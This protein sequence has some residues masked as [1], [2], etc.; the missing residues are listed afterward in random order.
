MLR[1]STLSL[2][3]LVVASLI[4]PSVSAQAA[5][6]PSAHPHVAEA[7]AVA[8]VVLLVREIRHARAALQTAA[9]LRERP[10]TADAPIE[11]VLCGGGSRSLLADAP[12]AA[13]L[14]DAAAAA[15]VQLL[16][17]GMSLDTLGIDPADLAT[18]VGVVANGLLHALDRQAA[19]FLSIEL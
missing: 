13:Q 1:L 6:P 18:G 7:P 3:A 4:A 11:L 10:A 19:G 16:A 12:E 14:V 2:T 17:C 5:P 15:G 9:S 8:G